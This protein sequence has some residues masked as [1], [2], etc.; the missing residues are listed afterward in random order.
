MFVFFFSLF[1]SY[2]SH[3]DNHSKFNTTHGT[4]YIVFIMDNILSSSVAGSV[5]EDPQAAN[6]LYIKLEVTSQ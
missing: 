1:L 2:L 5:D 4:H 3:V 6:F